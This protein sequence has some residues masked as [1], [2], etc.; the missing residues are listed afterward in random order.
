[1]VWFWQT[2]QRSSAPILPRP[3]LQH[4]IASAAR[5][6]SPLANRRRREPGDG[7]RER[8][9]RLI[10]RAFSRAINGSRVWFQSSGEIGSDMLVANHSGAIDQEGF[11]DGGDAEIDPGA[12]G[13]IGADPGI[14]DRRR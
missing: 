3:R 11:G 4:R 10:P 9:H 5:P 2:T 14:R 6:A 8:S 7:K 13:W 12:P 1:M